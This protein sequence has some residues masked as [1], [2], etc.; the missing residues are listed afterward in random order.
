M[1][2]QGVLIGCQD[3]IKQTGVVLE[4]VRNVIVRVIQKV[5][6]RVQRAEQLPVVV[7]ILGAGVE[8]IANDGVIILYQ[9]DE[10]VGRVNYQKE[11]QLETEEC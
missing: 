5:E 7:R 8:V 9:Y 2:I 6:P 3:D 10:K 4:S 11:L 1:C